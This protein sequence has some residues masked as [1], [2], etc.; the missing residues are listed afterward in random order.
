MNLI[1]KEGISLRVLAYAGH[2]APSVHNTQPWLMTLDET[3]QCL[4]I[5]KSRKRPL[6]HSDPAG[7]QT[8][9]SLGAAVENILQVADAVGLSSNAELRKDK[10]KVKISDRQT[11][12]SQD[13]HLDKV[14]RTIASR[15]SNRGLFS[16]KPPSPEIIEAIKDSCS[17][18]RQ[19]TTYIISDRDMINRLAQMVCQAT[20]LALSSKHL[21][22]E[23]ASHINPPYQSVKTGIPA[24]TISVMPAALFEKQSTKS[25]QFIR[26]K[27]RKEGVRI[28]NSSLLALTFTASDTSEDWVR[29]GREYEKLCL[30]I[31]EL[32]LSHSTNAALTEAPDYYK[33]VSQLLGT[34]MRLQTLIRVGYGKP[35]KTRASRLP[36]GDVLHTSNN[37]R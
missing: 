21:R 8:W 20:R 32:D 35:T 34:S 18:N 14:I 17:D 6:P 27:A 2:L 1:K 12:L 37:P 4:Y 13:E 16:K 31:T 30:K 24:R 33:E 22:L 25:S 9:I 36:L 26:Q 7:R 10:I 29:A 3:K 15:H 19:C 28:E 23:L 5:E 11:A